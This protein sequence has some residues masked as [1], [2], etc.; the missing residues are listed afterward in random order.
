MP[1]QET[2]AIDPPA[3]AADPAASAPALEAL[4]A[5]FPGA[6]YLAGLDDPWRPTW[7]SR[8]AASVGAG[9]AAGASLLDAA[10]PDDRARLAAWPPPG[11]QP[12]ETEHRLRAAEGR[13]PWVRHRRWAV[14]DEAGVPVGIEGT[15]EPIDP[16]GLGFLGLRDAARYL[17]MLDRLP[18]AVYL[19]RVGP[20]P[21]DDAYHVND[22]MVSLLGHPAEE[23][24]RGRRFWESLLHP[25]DRDAVLRAEAAL[26]A[27]GRF[28]MD[29]RMVARD[30]RVIWVHDEGSR[31][32]IL[33]DGAALWQGTLVDVTAAKQAAELARAQ[34]ERFRALVQRSQDL[35][36]VMDAEGRR[37]Y[38]SPACGP[39]LGYTEEELLGDSVLSLTHP[40]D[41]PALRAAIAETV[42]T[43]EP[44]PRL[45]LRIR[46]KDG[47]HR[48][49]EAVGTN[50]LD[51]PNVRGIV[52]N[53]RDITE[54]RQ[55]EDT[56]R[57]LAAI[58]DAAE[59]AVYAIDPDGI[60]LSWNPGAERL[61]GYRAAE[62]VGRHWE[63]L[64]DP[65]MQQ[66]AYDIERSAHEGQ[67]VPPG[68]TVMR[69][70]DGSRIDV[71]YSLGTVRDADANPAAIVSIVRDVTAEKR[72]VAA[73]EASRTR[74]R[75]FM[76]AAL[77]SIVGMDDAGLIT[78][79]NPAAERTFG[80]L[81][82]DAIGRRLS[83]VMIAP[84]LRE[85]HEHGMARYFATG[86]GPALNRRIETLGQRADG[87]VFPLEL[88]AIPLEVEGRPWFAG[89]LR[90]IT[91]RVEM[92][93]SLRESE[94]RLRGAVANAPIGMALV[95]LDGTILD[96]NRALH[97]LLGLPDGTLP[98]RA[99]EGLIDPE[100]R[101]A[102][103]AGAARLIAGDADS[104]DFVGRLTRGDGS[105]VW[106]RQAISA[107]DDR[108]GNPALLVFQVVDLTQTREADRLKN[109]FVATVSHEL[110]T[111]LTAISGFIDLMLDGAAGEL[112]DVAR[113]Y[114][115]VAQGNGRRLGALIND[116]LDMS[117]IEA[118]RLELRPA[119]VDLG[120]AVAQAVDSVSAQVQAKRQDLAVNLPPDLPAVHA[121]AGRLVQVLTNLLSNANRYTP[122]EGRIAVAATRDGAMVRVAVSDT[123]IGLSADQAAQVF[124]RFYQAQGGN[125]QLTGGTGL[126]LPITQSLVHLHGGE[127]GV[128]SAPGAGSTFW[129]TL[130][131]A[132]EAS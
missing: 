11:A 100:D 36:I 10:D 18:I 33:P 78:D 26:D 126:G 25:E 1:N 50:L 88:I 21:E 27:A 23:W 72:I 132:E 129:F 19:Q 67:R 31:L 124:D 13:P 119:P 84:H 71:S 63:F 70:A 125:R 40:D 6:V 35:I 121:D 22:R 85:P 115:T 98:E 52:F 41:V 77:D 91:D 60:I 7:V 105:Q 80:I 32:E 45:E 43:G 48:Q 90:D 55:A 96:A 39:L 56:R 47:T 101:P 29:Y 95:N 87:E 102:V 76:E 131:I 58:V 113:R 49:F 75:G 118:G 114:L 62:A 106:V 59:D 83:E 9:L 74:L 4:A 46:R 73:L 120:G 28:V 54:R 79:F 92:E 51:E 2:A 107:A 130:P 65:A 117:K 93:G 30:G 64:V 17:A 109:E 112:N 38:I 128:D 68:E 16:H 42:R 66:R 15:I 89:Y 82:E 44:T 5:A 34:D 20:T 103:I 108:H 37:S 104:V 97:A 127:I 81:R 53:S 14:V 122:D 12:E 123:G 24:R 99:W 69:H 111:P 3:P 94:E 61:F 86:H 116:L 110:R 57:L 8:G